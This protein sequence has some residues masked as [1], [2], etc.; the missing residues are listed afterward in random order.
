MSMSTAPLMGALLHMK[1]PSARNFSLLSHTDKLI[2]HRHVS[3]CWPCS[4]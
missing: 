3:N 1:P 4:S 2:L